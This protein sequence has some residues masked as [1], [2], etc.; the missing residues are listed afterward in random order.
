MWRNEAGFRV[1]N[2]IWSLAA[3][4]KRRK[5]KFNKCYFLIIIYTFDFY[6]YCLIIFYRNYGFIFMNLSINLILTYEGFKSGY[7]HHDPHDV[8]FI[9]STYRRSAS[10]CSILSTIFCLLRWTML[11]IYLR[12]PSFWLKIFGVLVIFGNFGLVSKE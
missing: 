3:V 10:I 11:R 9:S 2:S 4:S 8:L 12:F 1:S 7:L 6:G 5:N